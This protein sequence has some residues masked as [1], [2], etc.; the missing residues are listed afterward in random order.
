MT[1]G[2]QVAVVNG[3][4]LF[5]ESGTVPPHKKKYSQLDFRIDL[6]KTLRGGF[7]SRKRAPREAP[8]PVPRAA[9]AKRVIGQEEVPGH[10]LE[11]IS[12][13]ERKKVCR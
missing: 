12:G 4:I 8:S 9:G 1:F 6:Y 13:S 3:F 10:V 2:L 7:C 5:A 11:Q